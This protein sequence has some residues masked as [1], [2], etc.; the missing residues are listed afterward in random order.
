VHELKKFSSKS[1][2][3]SD[4]R[5]HSSPLSLPYTLHG[6]TD[7][8]FASVF[9]LD[10]ASVIT[11]DLD[12]ASVITLDLDFASVIISPDHLFLSVV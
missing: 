2:N 9:D 7:L 10:F 1:I 6:T 5:F 12:F 4:R 3:I 11:F 8:D